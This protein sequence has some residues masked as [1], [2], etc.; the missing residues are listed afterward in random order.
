MNKNSFELF[1]TEK[2]AE[3]AAQAKAAWGKTDAY[4]EYEKKSEGRSKREPQPLLMRLSRFTVN[5]N[6]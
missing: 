2:I 6:N 4:R 1:D 3:Y 5:K